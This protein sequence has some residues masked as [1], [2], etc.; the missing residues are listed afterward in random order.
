ML[1][2]LRNNVNKI[3]FSTDSW[4]LRD[5][6]SDSSGNQIQLYI[7]P[8]SLNYIRTGYASENTKYLRP[9][10]YLERDY[11]KNT[12]INLNTAGKYVKIMLRDEFSK[13]ELKNIYSDDELKLIFDRDD[14]VNVLFDF[15]VYGDE[16]AEV[17]MWN[18]DG[19]IPL[20]NK[21]LLD[22]IE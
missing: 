10:F 13:S 1:Y 5:Y 21:V 20:W 11:F 3:D 4:W 8:D 2:I 17:F 6:A 18:M 14:D 19:L 15:S 16:K 22:L 9:C 12:R 7:V